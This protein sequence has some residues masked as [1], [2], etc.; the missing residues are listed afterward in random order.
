M[1]EDLV[2]FSTV[3]CKDNQVDSF[4]L[5]TWLEPPLVPRNGKPLTL[6]FPIR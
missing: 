6:D 5:L 3:P 1:L 2:D 4:N